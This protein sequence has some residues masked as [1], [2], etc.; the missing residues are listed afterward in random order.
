MKTIVKACMAMLVLFT[1]CKSDPT[2]SE[3]Y[4]QLEQEKAT[5]ADQGTMKDSTINEMFG[6]FNR[7]SE[8]LRLI[9]EKQGLLAK[10]H[11]DVEGGTTMEQGIMDDLR[12]IDSLLNA[13]RAIIA[14]M[15]KNSAADNAQLSELKKAI[16]GFEETVR[17][18][19]AEIGSI[20]EQLASTNA[21]LA[22]MIQMY[23]DKEQQANMQLAE[24]NAA[25][26]CTGTQKEL[27][28]NRILTK[29][30]GVIGIGSVNKLNTAD[31]NKDY[32]KQIDITQTTTIPLGAK[33]AK[34]VT[35]H[36]AGSY[37][38]VSGKEGVESLTIKDAAAF[39]SVSK[40]LVV[41]LD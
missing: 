17:E 31:L 25:W 39:W 10:G 27:R 9:R 26:Y 1:A 13:N 20:K 24:L 19:D 8:N 29:E 35:T 7:V 12:A 38:L 33:K 21:S 5:V 18:K 36:P 6:A 41:Q 3:E 2:Q 34:V 14:R 37:E 11:K 30:G 23:Q 32:F 28:D 4:K 22:S 40:Y 15:K 16:A